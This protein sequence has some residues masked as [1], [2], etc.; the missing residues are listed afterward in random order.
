M[1]KPNQ[2]RNVMDELLFSGTQDGYKQVVDMQGIIHL[3]PKQHRV[4][5]N[6]HTC[7]RRG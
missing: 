3:R 1:P 5:K 4:I 2:N 6:K 7:I